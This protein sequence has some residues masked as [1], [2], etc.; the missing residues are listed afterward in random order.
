MTKW[1]VRPSSIAAVA[2]INGLETGTYVAVYLNEDKTEVT[3]AGSTRVRYTLQDADFIP[4]EVRKAV[5]DH[6]NHVFALEHGNV[7]PSP[8]AIYMQTVK[9]ITV[10]AARSTTI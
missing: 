3:G 1:L 4:S 6:F 5:Q 10:L 7:H 9:P 8:R 2:Y